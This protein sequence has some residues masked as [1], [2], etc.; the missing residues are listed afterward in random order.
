MSRADGVLRVVLT[1][2]WFDM[3]ERGEKLEEYRKDKS[4]E[5]FV[6]LETIRAVEHTTW[7]EKLFS[8]SAWL[9][10]EGN[11]MPRCRSVADRIATESNRNTFHP[12]HTLVASHGYTSRTLTRKIKRIRWGQPRPEW[13]GDTVTGACF[14]IE[15]EATE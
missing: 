9:D 13:S 5:Y 3:I 8:D 1:G 2:K 7:S 15:L 12:Y 4:T 14:I 11:P 6:E 10:G